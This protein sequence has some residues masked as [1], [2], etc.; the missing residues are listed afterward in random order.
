MPVKKKSSVTTK[1]IGSTIVTAV[2]VFGVK[3]QM[4][5][6]N[7]Q[8]Q[9]SYFPIVA[10]PTDR[11]QLSQRILPALPAITSVEVENVSYLNTE[12][13]F[14]TGSKSNQDD[15]QTGPSPYKLKLE[16]QKAWGSQPRRTSFSSATKHPV[17]LFKTIDDATPQLP[18]VPGHE[19]P[20]LGYESQFLELAVGIDDQQNQQLTT[21]DI[22]EFK[23]LPEL[24]PEN[25][26]LSA[27]MPPKELLIESVS[28]APAP[29]AADPA[30]AAPKFSPAAKRAPASAAKVVR[31][32]ETGRY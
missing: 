21:N 9:I 24:F 22:I 23:E 6:D 29:V 4:P 32:W 16:D 11:S 27:P 13:W 19:D 25:N 31:A 12:K 10:V 1:L 2:V 5:I 20:H 17:G 30:R 15:F 7:Q 8:V 18:I 14:Q 3:N 26:P 28:V